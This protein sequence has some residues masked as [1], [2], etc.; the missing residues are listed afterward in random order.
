MDRCRRCNGIELN[1]HFH[2]VQNQPPLAR[3]LFIDFDSNTI[4]KVETHHNAYQLNPDNLISNN[5]STSGLY[6]IGYL[7]CSDHII[8]SFRREMEKCDSLQAIILNHSISGG[9]GSGLVCRIMQKIKEDL[10]AKLIITN[11]VV[12]SVSEEIGLT[13]LTTLSIYNSMFSI[14]EI[15]D[16]SD[17]SLIHDNEA[18][19][20]FEYDQN[21]HTPTKDHWDILNL[22]V[23]KNL[24]GLTSGSRFQGLNQLNLGKIMTNL[25]PHMNFHIFQCQYFEDFNHR[26][27]FVKYVLEEMIKNKK[28][29]FTIN[30]NKEPRLISTA[31][32]F[33]GNDFFSGELEELNCKPLRKRVSMASKPF[34]WSC[35]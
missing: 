9:T 23:S 28:S 20:A 31:S 24:S 14:K 21:F 3:F 10:N 15:Q 5:E 29:L 19:M 6:T 13:D 32:F 35:L 34:N 4:N 18:L 2:E 8:D 22:L 25:I 26:P 7:K 33:R 27:D 30:P 16:Y 12:P 17:L 1:V 11:T